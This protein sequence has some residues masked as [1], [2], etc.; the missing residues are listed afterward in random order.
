MVVRLGLGEH[1]SIWWAPSLRVLCSIKVYN[2]QY[3]CLPYR[4]QSRIK[5]KCLDY[6][7]N[8]N[9]PGDSWS[10]VTFAVSIAITVSLVI[11]LVVNG[12]LS[13]AA[14]RV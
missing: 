13:S 7:R 4:Q 9:V 3:K 5:N 6:S 1:F 10:S 2:L 14:T 8:S 11:A 12:A